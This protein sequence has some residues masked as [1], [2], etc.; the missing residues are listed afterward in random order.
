MKKVFCIFLIL[1]CSGV[2]S[3]LN[4]NS[5]IDS[6]VSE[7]ISVNESEAPIPCSMIGTML[8]FEAIDAGYSVEDADI[9]A[10]RAEITCHVA[11]GWSE[12]LE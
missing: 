3:G 1:L 7:N 11:T 9:I 4:S 5:G 6:Y 2:T 10:L 8:F 12:F